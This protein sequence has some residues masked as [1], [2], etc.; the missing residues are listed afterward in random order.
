[1]NGFNPEK[2]E[3]FI[4]LIIEN[5]IWQMFFA[6]PCRVKTYTKD[7]QKVE[8]ELLVKFRRPVQDEEQEFTPIPEIPVGFMNSDSGNC[9]MSFP[10]KEGDL[11]WVFF[12]TLDIDNYLSGNADTPVNSDSYA[13]Q[14]LKDAV[15]IPMFRPWNK[16]LQNVS[17]DNIRIQNTD[18][19]F[20]VRNDGKWQFTG[21][22]YEMLTELS[23]L[24]QHLLDS[25]QTMLDAIGHIK[26]AL[27]AIATS[28]TATALG[29][30]PLSG[31]P[32]VVT[33]I[34]NITTDE[35]NLTGNRTDINTDKTHFDELKV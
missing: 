7:E 21:V 9:Y 6:L 4:E 24:M 8:V 25:H 29:P 18:S 28:T 22:N 12:S 27:N 3:E 20:E 30:Q 23:N 26:S 17:A 16:A 19:V 32:T 34:A 13:R 35:T 5:K 31:A 1:M 33:E 2:L 10:I 15:F 11:G 14:Q